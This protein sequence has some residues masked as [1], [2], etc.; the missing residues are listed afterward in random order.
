[1]DIETPKK[2]LCIIR[3]DSIRGQTI[4]SWRDGNQWVVT[5]GDKEARYQASMWTQKNSV[6]AFAEKYLK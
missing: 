4:K 5:S 1:M 6:R 3:I 2:E